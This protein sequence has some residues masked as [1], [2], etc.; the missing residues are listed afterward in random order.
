M[1]KRQAFA[2][3]W[4][5]KSSPGG[6]LPIAKEVRDLIQRVSVENQLWGATKIHSDLLKLGIG[7]AQSTVSI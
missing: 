3:Y 4:R 1:A 7:V 6:R 5:C 2:A